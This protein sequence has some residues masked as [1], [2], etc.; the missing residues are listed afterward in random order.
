MR[1]NHYRLII[2]SVTLF[3]FLTP[4]LNAQAVTTVS[5]SSSSISVPGTN[6]NWAKV[7]TREKQLLKAKNLVMTIEGGT[8][9][10]LP[11]RGC[12]VLTSSVPNLSVGQYLPAFAAKSPEVASNDGAAQFRCGWCDIAVSAIEIVIFVASAATLSPAWLAISVYVLG[13]TIIMGYL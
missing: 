11:D 5:P 2:I 1:K 7:S 3:S 4:T 12:K 6:S 8:C 10:F 13:S 9:L